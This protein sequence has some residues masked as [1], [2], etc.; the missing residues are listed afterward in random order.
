[1]K[2]SASE[3]LAGIVAEVEES[4]YCV[5]DMAVEVAGPQDD[6]VEVQRRQRDTVEAV[7]EHRNHV[8]RLRSYLAQAHS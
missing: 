5:R 1:M 6:A 2:Y 4:V 7:A 8:E 3:V